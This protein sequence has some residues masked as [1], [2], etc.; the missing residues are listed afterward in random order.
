MLYQ[1]S[2]AAPARSASDARGVYD[3]LLLCERDTAGEDGCWPWLG[4][5]KIGYGAF[6]TGT[7]NVPAHRWSFE[8]FVRPL[9]PG[10]Q[11]HHLCR[12]ADCVRPTHLT[13]VTRQEHVQLS[14]AGHVLGRDPGFLTGDLE[15]CRLVD[16]EILERLEPCT[17]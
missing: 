13:A 8:A 3:F 4:P 10:E 9:E 1:S 17:H 2:R 16:T 5:T 12:Y 7:R 15:L 6:W 11:V 14:R